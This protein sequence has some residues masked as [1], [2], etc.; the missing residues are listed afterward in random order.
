MKTIIIGDVH[1]C[2][3][4]LNQLLLELAPAEY[5]HLIFIGDLIDRGPDSAGVVERVVELS[6]RHHVSLILGNH[7]EKFL[8]YRRH[9]EEGKGVELQMSGSE[10]FPMLMER[11]QPIHFEFLEGAY[12]ALH[13]P[14]YHTL[15][16]HGGIP[17]K[18]K[19]PFPVT[20]RYGEHAPRDYPGLDLLTK[21]RF[22]DDNGSFVALNEQKPQDQ[23]WAETY[24]GRY[25]HVVFG[26]QPFMEA[27]PKEFPFATGVDTGCV[28]GGKLSALVLTVAL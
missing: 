8:R 10:E 20:Y 11:L 17:G 15:L 28:Y 6:A 25:G 26:H 3:L 5:D 1:G 16:V 22:L 4:E 19:F 27:A 13:L 12:Y 2:L 7:E 18:V 21:T 23:F 24:D 9:L 14:E